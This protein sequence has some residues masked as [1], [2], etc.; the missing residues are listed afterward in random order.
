MPTI[1]ELCQ[2]I[3]ATWIATQVREDLWLFPVL[4][5][6][7]I[8]GLTLS[9]GMLLWFDLRL[10]GVGLRNCSVSGLYRR[11]MPFMLPAFFVMVVSGSLL[12][13]GFATLAY[14]NLFFRIKL[15]GLIVAGINAVLFHLLTERRLAQWDDARVLP[16]AARAAGLVSIISWTVV[17]LAGRMI[18]YTMYGVAS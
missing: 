5:S 8:L 7:H 4:V 16:L 17:I 11:L 3:E 15:C 1:Y 18:S 9:V 10:L 14:D 13:A 6:I 2:R 12:F